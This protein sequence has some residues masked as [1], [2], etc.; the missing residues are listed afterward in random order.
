MDVLKLNTLKYSSVRYK[1]VL[2]VGSLEL[3]IDLA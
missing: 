1:Q 3:K 2:Y